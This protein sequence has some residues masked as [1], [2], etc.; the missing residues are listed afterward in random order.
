MIDN[1]FLGALGH[2]ATTQGMHGD[3]TVV[4]EAG[5]Q[6]IADVRPP[7]A[8]GCS[9]HH[10]VD[11]PVVGTRTHAGPV[12]AHVVVPQ[13]QRSLVVVLTHEEKRLEMLGRSSVPTAEEPDDGGQALPPPTGDRLLRRPELGDELARHNFGEQAG[14]D[15]VLDDRP[16]PTRLGAMIDE[17]GDARAGRGRCVGRLVTGAHAA[18]DHVGPFG[19]ADHVPV[20]TE[21][22]TQAFR[23]S[24]FGSSGAEEDLRRPERSCRQHDQIGGDGHGR[25]MEGR[26]PTEAEGLGMHDPPAIT[27]PILNGPHLEL[28]EDGGTVGTGIGQVV[29]EHRVLGREIAARNAVFTPDTGRLV[30]AGSVHAAPERDV[31]GRQRNALTSCR[32]VQGV[33]LG[34][35]G[36][37]RRVGGGLEHGSC[38]RIPVRQCPVDRGSERLGPPP[39][40]EDRWLGLKRHVGVDQ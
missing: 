30:D 25:G 4:K 3:Q 37:R 16:V 9:L 7:A 32:H 36:E 24:Q 21:A 38:R 22:M 23:D 8:P 18:H 1:P 26:V 14:D 34:E 5:A 33:D 28:G 29:H 2:D 35:A 6:G 39:I 17:G 19:E 12:D 15:G 27:G 20:P 10:P 40:V 11:S 13:D 31:D